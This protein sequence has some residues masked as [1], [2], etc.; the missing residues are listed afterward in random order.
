M[1]SGLGHTSDMKKR[2]RDNKEMLKR[3]SYFD[4][5]KPTP[6]ALPKVPSRL[7]DQIR[8]EN[9][10]SDIIRVVITILLFFSIVLFA[11]FML[12]GY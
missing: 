1:G 3:N 8:R 11:V 9:K 10:R 2:L 12:A 7:K 4:K 6:E 5:S